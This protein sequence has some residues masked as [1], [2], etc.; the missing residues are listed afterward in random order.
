MNTEQGGKFRE[1][2]KS[3]SSPKDHKAER[4]DFLKKPEASVG[5]HPNLRLFSTWGK[6]TGVM[7]LASSAE[8][9]LLQTVVVDLRGKLS[10]LHHPPV[11]DFENG[12]C[13]SGPGNVA[14]LSTFLLRS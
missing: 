10:H 8:V 1:S 2:M 11:L 3:R 13:R 4:R 14:I 9:S 12:C 6:C 5:L 7:L